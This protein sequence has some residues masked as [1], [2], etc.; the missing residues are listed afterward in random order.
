MASCWPSWCARAVSP[1]VC[2]HDSCYLGRYQDVYQA[3]RE[4]I[5]GAGA[6][7][8]EMERSGKNSFCCGAGGGRMWLEENEGE[9]INVARTKQAL[10]TGADAVACACPFCLTMLTDGMTALEGQKDVV[11]IAELLAGVLD[12]ES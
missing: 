12:D 2:F 5:V 4:V 1:S 11:D 7:V 8:V 3:P 6:A 9:R 10:D